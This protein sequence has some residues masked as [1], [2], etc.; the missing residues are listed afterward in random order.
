MRQVRPPRPV[1]Q[2]SEGSF[3]TGELTAA[4]VNRCWAARVPL[5]R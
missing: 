5:S 1:E 2:L 3:A 4:G